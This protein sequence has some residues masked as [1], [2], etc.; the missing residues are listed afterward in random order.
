MRIKTCFGWKP[1]EVLVDSGTTMNFITQIAAK[2]LDLPTTEDRALSVTTL[3]GH[4]L[5]TYGI[6]QSQLRVKDTNKKQ[7]MC[8]K[9]LVTADMAGY[10][11]ILRMSWLDEH[12]PD[13]LWKSKTWT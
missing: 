13:V 3:D 10:D 5:L 9:E 6:H 11:M 1:L 2:E 7:R 12:E 4:T 8:I